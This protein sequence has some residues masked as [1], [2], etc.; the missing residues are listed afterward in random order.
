ME[1]NVV[2][3]DSALTRKRSMQGMV[4]ACLLMISWTGMGWNALGTYSVFV[5]EDLGCSTAQFMIIFTILSWVNAAISMTI[6]GLC[7]DKFGARK[8][9]LFG[10]LFCTAGFALFGLSQSIQFMWFAATIFAIGL[11]FININTL[12]VMINSWFKK[13]TAR[14]TGIAQSFGPL[15]GA[16]FN[17]LWGI[18]MVMIGFRIPFYISAVISLIFTFLVYILYVN[19]ENAGC[20]ARGEAELMEEARENAG[21]EEEVTIE[22]GLS[23][24]ATVK[25][26]RSWLL[27]ICYI[28]A[29][30][31]D[32]GLLGNFALI[33]AS[34]GD[35]EQAG[36]IMGF[37]WLFQIAAFLVLGTVCDKL[38]SKYSQLV[39]FIMVI[40]VSGLFLADFVS[41]P[42]VF[43]AA[44]MLGFADGAVQLPMG[45]SAREALGTKDF[46]KKMGLVGGGC[47]IGVGV[48]TVVVARIF[49]VTGS[50]K[51]AFI[52]IIALSIVTALLFF[53]ATRSVYTDKE[54]AEERITVK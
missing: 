38:G 3:G 51:P 18:V 46:A 5:V 24:G 1:R 15:G 42:V 50:Y 43:L 35:A 41:L 20:P 52:L 6:Y 31:C 39:C 34:H 2:V 44:A 17:S 25:K 12:N 22:T 29:G 33:A 9:I 27:P 30:I 10:G 36:F 13:N 4:A 53:V 11:A 48:S 47:Y 32:Y 54:V 45:A 19:Q 23:F 21:A 14:Y 28:L 16:F 40:I 49:D 8:M 37:S 7:I 26:G